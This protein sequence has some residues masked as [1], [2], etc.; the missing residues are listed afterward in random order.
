MS[1]VLLKCLPTFLFSFTG[2]PEAAM[3]KVGF[4][5]MHPEIPKEMS[6]K[7][8]SFMLRC[9]EK[10]PQTRATATELLEDPFNTE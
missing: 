3:F 5:K 7:A 8:Q 1:S 6:E 4:Y 2:T 9:F 10:D